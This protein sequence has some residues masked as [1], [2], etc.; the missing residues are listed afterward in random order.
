MNK[1]AILAEILRTAEDNQGVP[2]GQERFET[3]TGISPGTWRGK[4]WRTWGEAVKEA[5]LT[6]QKKKE[7]T[8]EAFMIEYLAKLARKNGRW[9][10]QADLRMER[11]EN[12][13]CPSIHAFDRLGSTQQRAALVLAFIDAHP[14]YEDVRGFV[15]ANEAGTTERQ[16]DDSAATEGFV[17]MIKAGRHYKIGKTFSVPRR[18]R[19]ISLELPEK[20]D[21]VHTIRTDDPSGIEAYWHGRFA[22]RR[23]NGEW[24]ALTGDDVRAFKRRKFM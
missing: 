15:P 3:E 11:T 13:D 7:A 23:A 1:A 18:H 22:A 16:Q 17:Y 19:E 10:T 24:F 21:V 5:G 8:S 12:P 2:L 14:D 4:F 20:P 6:P 9:P